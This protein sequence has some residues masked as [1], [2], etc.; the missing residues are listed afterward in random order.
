MVGLGRRRIAAI[1]RESAQGTASVRLDGYRQALRAA[2]I[3]DDP[4]LVVAVAHS[5][6]EDGKVAME[7]LLGLPEPLYEHHRLIAGPDGRRLA[8][9]DHAATL[10]AMRQAGARPADIL[11]Q[12]R[13][14][15]A[16]RPD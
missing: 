14:P 9:R 15:A 3:D 8:K 12:L 5:E 10:Q 6:R 4:E 7:S 1:G 13:E 2:R 16:P 11:S